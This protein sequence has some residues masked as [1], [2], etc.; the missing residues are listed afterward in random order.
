MPRQISLR[1]NDD[2]FA[3][4]AARAKDTGVSNSALVRLA[5]ESYLG[6]LDGQTVPPEQI[7]RSAVREGFS[8]GYALARGRLEQ[9]FTELLAETR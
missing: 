8:A 4:L 7:Y 1:L 3:Q 9:M 2:V 5:V 6:S